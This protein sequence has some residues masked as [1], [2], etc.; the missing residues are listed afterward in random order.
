MEHIALLSS[1]SGS[2][3]Q[4]IQAIFHLLADNSDKA[5][6]ILSHS[7]SNDPSPIVRHEAAY[8]LGEK[9]TVL[10]IDPLIQAIGTDRHKIVVHESLLALANLGSIAYP[11]S[12]K[13]I[14]GQLNNAD[15]DVV[16][17]AE[18]ALQRL[19]MKLQKVEIPTDLKSLLKILDD[20]GSKNKE[21]RIQASFV[22][23]DNASTESVDL[24]ISSL[25]REP[26]PIVKHE[27]IFSLGESIHYKV[28]PELIKVLQTDKNFFTV[29]EAL[30]ALGTLGDFKAESEIRKFL[31][32][33]DPAI[34]ESAEISLERLTS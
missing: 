27:L 24:L 14:E 22:L 18:I 5:I 1:F 30:L 23:M 34:V 26:S 3:E 10:S 21:Y 4:R 33:E 7:L 8:I 6:K 31:H 32:H 13:V 19:N 28:V 12:Q 2:S 9:A 25:E 20:L 11:E 16:D 15:A 29:H 17:T